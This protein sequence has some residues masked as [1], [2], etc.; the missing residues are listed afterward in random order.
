MPIHKGTQTIK[1]PRLTL[2]RFTPDDV[3]AVYSNWAN[4]PEVT[5]FLR[6]PAHPHIRMT[7]QVLDRWISDYSHSDFYHWAIVPD[8][9]GDPVGSISAVGHDDRTSMVHI[10]YCLGKAWWHQGYMSES[11]A[12]V[13][14][15]FFTQIGINRIES[16]H[17]PDNPRS[18]GMM[19]KC[20]MVYEGTKRQ[21][22]FTNKGIADACM[23]S[24]LRSEWSDKQ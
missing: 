6:W 23:Y 8:D 20:G 7:M 12:A 5:K 3:P 2:R 17:D 13:I 9:I 14:K 11:L 1:T 15:F 16:Q 21:A 4:N 19:K 18:G 10:G 22:D 24:I